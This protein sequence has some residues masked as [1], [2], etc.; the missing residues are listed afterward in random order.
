M[1]LHTFVHAIEPEHL[2]EGLTE[3][4]ILQNF[5]AYDVNKIQQFYTARDYQSVW[6]K[7]DSIS[8]LFD[9]VFTLITDAESDG[10]DSKDYYLAQLQQRFSQNNLTLHE[11]I[12]L[13]LLTTHAVLSL[14]EDLSRGRFTASEADPDWHIPQPSFDTVNFLIDALASNE[15]TQKFHKLAPQKPSYQL[16]KQTLAHYRKLAKKQVVWTKIPDATIIDPGETH[17]TIPLIR[18]RI[19][20]A[21][22]TDQVKAYELTDFDS[23]YYDEELE[24]AIKAFQAQHGLNMDGVIGRLTTHALNTTLDRKIRQLRIN[25]ERLRWLPRDLGSRYLLVNLAG[26]RLTAAEYGEHVFDMRI[27]V[28][29]YFRSTPSFNSKISHMVLNPYWNVPASI[30]RKD[31]LPKQQENPEYFTNANIKVYAGYNYDAGALDPNTIDWDEIKQ[32]FPYILR[33]DPGDK[34]AL[35]TIKFMF[36]N[37]FNIYLHDTPTKSLFKE[38]IRTFSSG[39]IRLEEPLKLAMFLLEE[40]N[41]TTEFSNQLESTRT[42]SIN[43]PHLL[44]IYL[45]YLTSWVDHLNKVHFS[46]DTYERDEYALRYAGW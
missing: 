25:M 29:R 31:L 23:P 16:L 10:L 38:D 12:E 40:Q 9:T 7:S 8:P 42:K 39:C 43:L 6:M 2:Q 30:A 22:H 1:F 32:G 45:V 20:E 5:S 26:F 35:G 24:A 4:A 11:S 13:E 27:I 36:P 3:S 41:L 15:L 34:N 44:P 28:G 19:A 17:Q 46:P 37:P 21:Y 33:Q 18:K 14:A